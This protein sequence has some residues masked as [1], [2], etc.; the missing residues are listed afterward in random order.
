LTLACG[1]TLRKRSRG[2]GGGPDLDHRVKPT[3]GE[4]ALASQELRGR[5]PHA[6]ADPPW[7]RRSID[8]G[9]GSAVASAHE[10][11]GRDPVVQGAAAAHAAG[12][13]EDQRLGN[14]RG[15]RREGDRAGGGLRRSSRRSSTATG[16]R[17]RSSIGSLGHARISRA[18]ER[19]AN[20]QAPTHSRRGRYG[21]SVGLA[22]GAHT[23]GGFRLP[24]FAKREPSY[25]GPYRLDFRGF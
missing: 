4:F 15:D 23:I 22:S 10:W 14:D 16:L 13:E 12:C 21:G 25:S 1:T 8:R 17:A 19:W 9:E 6:G 3:S 7:C 20:T 24:V 18:W 5:R 11:H 2:D